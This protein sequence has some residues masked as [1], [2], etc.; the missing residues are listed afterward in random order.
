MRQSTGSVGEL[1][2]ATSG[3]RAAVLGQ[4]ARVAASQWISAPASS[5][6]SRLST[7]SAFAMPPSGARRGPMKVSA[8]GGST[9]G[10][11]GVLSILIAALCMGQD[12][13]RAVSAATTPRDDAAVVFPKGHY[14]SLNTLPDWGGIWLPDPPSRG[15]PPEA[16]MLKGKYLTDYVAWRREFETHRGEVPHQA[17]YCRPPGMPG[18]LSVPQYP[19]EFLFTPG[20]VT[21]NFEAWMQRRVIYTDGRAHPAEL[22]PTFN[23][24]SVGAW[25]GDTLIVHTVGIKDSLELGDLPGLGLGMHHSEKL[26]IVEH[27]HLRPREPDVLVIDM[28]AEDSDAFEATCSCLSSSAR[29][30]IAIP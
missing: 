6:R 2:G 7:K 14:A 28:T 20:R 8:R 27:I 17:S 1:A 13:G 24:D 19:I 3:R 11:R 16:P 22:D 12:V 29:R 23:G 4:P 5:R 26:Q 10:R 15:L 25:Q 9:N 30:T 18:I 21:L